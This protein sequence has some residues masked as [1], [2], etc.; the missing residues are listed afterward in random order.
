[1]R[2]SLA[3]LVT[4]I[5][6]A[7]GPAWAQDGESTHV[8]AAS[9]STAALNHAV[10][11]QLPFQDRADFEAA[12]RGLVA[13]FEGEIKNAAG[14]PVW[15][16]HQYDFLNQQDAPDSVNPSLW[17]MAQLNANAGLF[18]V[19]E[20]I[21]QVRGID[22]ANMTVIEGDDGL[23]IIDP[24]YMTETAKAGLELYYQHR[25]RKPVVA[26]IYS[27]SH[28]DHFG[29]VRGVVDEAEVKAG[30]VRI[31]APEG[32]MEH[33]IQENVLAGTAMF[34]RGAYQS[35]GAVPRNEHGQVDTGIGKA[36][37]VG[38]TISLI[39]PTDLIVQ[40]LQKQ[41]IAGVQF[42]FQLTPGTEAPAEMN[43]YLPQM[44]ALCMS[45]NAVMSMHNVLTPRGAQV[46]DAKAWGQFLDDSL[47]RYGDKA[48]VM[49]AQ[50]NWPTW[51]SE[52]IRTLLADQR[53]MYAF[54][55]NRTLH[56]LNQGMTPLEIADAMKKL[57][58]QLDQK[59]YARGYYG[60][61]SFN[62]RAVYQ[63]YLGF[64]DANPAN[65]DPLPPVEAGKHYVQAM[66]GADK[67]LAQMQAAMDRGDY[68]WAA[69]LGNH[70]VF[71]EPGNP[72]ARQAQA[73]A[74]EQLG[75]RSESAIWRNM[76]LTGAQELRQVQP[77]QAPQA[78]SDLIRA[79]TPAMFMDVLAVRMDSDKAQGHDMTVNWNFSDLDQ[80]FALTLR[81]GVLTYRER[82]SHAQADAT[83]TMSK[84]VMDRISLRQ[85]D[86]P[87]AFKQGDIKLEG[88]AQRFKAM[89]GMLASFQPTFNIVTP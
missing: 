67:V 36:A 38:G 80:H 87:T 82:A 69:Q 78:T 15:N 49:F 52:G 7:G 70:L 4:A 57:P 37:G 61:L 72:R 84:D 76:Y 79:A 47:V 5:T 31:Y 22:L 6:L 88:D 71:A 25:P 86:F 44:Q 20:K 1:M 54:I 64:Y 40:P 43:V 28:V 85:L 60:T 74:L 75:Y 45:E 59:W 23:I 62:S 55:N 77:Q 89:L 12:R 51:G 81:N 58:G 39:A 34:R 24:L 66:G 83:V 16:T 65:L 9:P 3:V 53:D 27:H 17:R 11:D 68:R 30:K 41:V 50:H 48:Q 13:A 73:D 8:K 32:F 29:G 10:L 42:E 63:R 19:T 21:Y 14:K 26:V 56:L 46:R 18:Q 35:G 2:N 33:A